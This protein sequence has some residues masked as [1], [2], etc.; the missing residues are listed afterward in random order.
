MKKSIILTSL[1]VLALV[2]VQCKNDDDIGASKPRDYA[3]QYATDLADIETFLKTHS[4]EVVNHPGYHDDQDVTFD[5][6]AEGSPDAIW[7]SPNLQTRMVKT[8]R[9]AD[10]DVEYKVYYL[11]LREGGGAL[12]TRPSPCN[13]DAVLAAYSGRYMFHLATEDAQGNAV[14]SLKTFEFETNPFPQGDLNLGETIR[15]WS[16]IFPQFKSGDATQVDGSPTLYTDFGAGVMFLPSAL[17][18]YNSGSTNIPAYSPLIFTFKL[19]NVTRLD[20]D[21]DGIPNYLEDLDHDG[22]MYIMLDA[23]GNG[24]GARP[25]DIDNDGAPNYLDQDDDGDRVLTNVEL[26]VDQNN[27]DGAKYTFDTAPSCSGDVTTIDRLRLIY[28]PSCS[29]AP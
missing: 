12:G 28:D 11:K 13:A 18:Y 10:E 3:T 5:T 6:V 22:Y 15:G 24:V 7:A 19:Y 17:G 20:T 9:T 21:N 26:L 27:P 23:D 8:Y 25:D 1:L 2:L 14:D 4:Y 16:E 29:Q